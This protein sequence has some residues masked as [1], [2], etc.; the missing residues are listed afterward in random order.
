LVVAH[1]TVAHVNVCSKKGVQ[2]GLMLLPLV[3]EFL[4]PWLGWLE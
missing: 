4:Y 1:P 2:L 3:L